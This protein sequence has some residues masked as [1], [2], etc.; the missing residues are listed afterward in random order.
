MGSLTKTEEL[1]DY[2]VEMKVTVFVNIKASSKKKA[3]QMAKDIAT[4]AEHSYYAFVSGAPSSIVN[5]EEG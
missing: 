1:K 4:S 2:R 3:K 5:V